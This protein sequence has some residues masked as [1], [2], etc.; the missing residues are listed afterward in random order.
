LHPACDWNQIVFKVRE[1]A[2][3]GGCIENEIAKTQVAVQQAGVG[4]AVLKDMYVQETDPVAKM[5]LLAL[6][7]AAMSLQ[8]QLGLF[9]V[10]SGWDCPALR[11]C[12]FHVSQLADP[13]FKDQ[14]ARAKVIKL[15]GQDITSVASEL[16]QGVEVAKEKARKAKAEAD[17]ASARAR[18]G[19]AQ[20]RI[21]EDLARR[22]EEK[23]HC[24]VA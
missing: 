2:V 17:L 21:D 12:A 24:G 6:V 14:T 8:Y 10:V 1:F 11:A 7:R 22:Q 5:E 23:W 18:S 19:V 4:L 3:A 20:A 16:A 15:L 13:N 9:G